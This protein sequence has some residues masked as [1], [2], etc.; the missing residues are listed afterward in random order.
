MDERTSRRLN[1]I[2]SERAYD[3][4]NQL[5]KKKDKPM[6]DVVRDAVALEKWVEETTEKG[7]RLLV[8]DRDGKI[9]E[10]VIR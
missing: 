7:G 5:A 9:R 1:V 2:F 6:A 3:Q 8:E 10:V 4:L